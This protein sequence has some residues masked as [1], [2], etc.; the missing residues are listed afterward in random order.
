AYCLIPITIFN[1]NLLR[2]NYDASELA[3]RRAESF[4]KI[5]PLKKGD[6]VLDIATGKG[7]IAIPV[8]EMIGKNATILQPFLY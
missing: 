8:A 1:A 5:L 4:L 7:L 6:K 2:T 3:N